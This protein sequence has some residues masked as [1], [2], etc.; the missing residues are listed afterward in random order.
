MELLKKLTHSS[1]DPEKIALTIK[2]GVPFIIFLL[3][4]FGVVNIGTNDLLHLID[5]IL[6]V[7]MGVIA[8]YGLGRKLYY[9]T[10]TLFK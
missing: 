5:S 4:Y 1:A 10:A 2:A 3:P 6:A 9:E 7:V 8:T